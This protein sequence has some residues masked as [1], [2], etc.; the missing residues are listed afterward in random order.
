MDTQGNFSDAA[1]EPGSSEQ[2]KLDHSVETYLAEMPGLGFEHVATFNTN[3]YREGEKVFIHARRDGAIVMGR[4]GLSIDE[5][6]RVRLLVQ[7]LPKD[8]N[9]E[10]N[11]MHMYPYGGGWEDIDPQNM[12]WTGDFIFDKKD[13]AS[14]LGGLKWSVRKL[15]EEGSFTPIPLK[16]WDFKNSLWSNEDSNAMKIKW[17]L[18]DE[19][20]DQAIDELKLSRARAIAATNPWFLEMA[21]IELPPEPAPVPPLPGS[22]PK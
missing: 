7:W 14:G 4:T 9:Q 15:L 18:K 19:E 21:G 8:Q 6:S 22:E 2:P 20:L 3:Y 13:Y 1:S 10:W 5:I 12:A 11:P 16:F 17:G